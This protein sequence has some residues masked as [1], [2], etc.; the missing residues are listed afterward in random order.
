[1]AENLRFDT[2]AGFIV[3]LF[4]AFI[5]LNFY[6]SVLSNIYLFFGPYKYPLIYLFNTMLIALFI[7]VYFYALD[8]VRTDSVERWKF[9]RYFKQIGNIFYA[10]SLIFSKTFIL[11][12]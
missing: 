1:M 8:Y 9:F 10:F 2:K 6:A 4:A 7:S 5:A 12:K 3:A 11:S